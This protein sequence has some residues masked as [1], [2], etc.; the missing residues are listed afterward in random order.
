M[1][2]DTI[3]N[4]YDSNGKILKCV[5]NIH[6]NLVKTNSRYVII[7][8]NSWWRTVITSQQYITVS[9]ISLIINN[10]ILSMPDYWHGATMIYRCNLSPSLN[11]E[12]VWH[13]HKLMQCHNINVLKTVTVIQYLCTRLVRFI[14]QDIL[15]WIL[16]KHFTIKACINSDKSKSI[17][18]ENKKNTMYLTYEKLWVVVNL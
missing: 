12:C 5:K 8:N 16:T 3:R 4:I 1:E 10:F 17:A 2:K 15:S 11:H 13:H 7:T 18:K 14:L 9:L 6:P